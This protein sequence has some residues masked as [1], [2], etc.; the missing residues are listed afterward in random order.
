MLWFLLFDCL[1]ALR[2]LVSHEESTF[3]GIVLLKDLRGE[4]MEQ[5]V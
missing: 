4:V 1:I 5:R 2:L 3:Y